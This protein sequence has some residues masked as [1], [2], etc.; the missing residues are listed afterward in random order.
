MRKILLTCAVALVAA[1]PAQANDG[2]GA[3]RGAR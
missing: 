3:A 2:G 1:V